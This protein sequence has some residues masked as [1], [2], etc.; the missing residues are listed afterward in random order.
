[1][2]LQQ[3]LQN[4]GRQRA[5]LHEPPF[6]Q[7][8]RH[9]AEHARADRL[10]VV[11]DQHRRVAIEADVA[12]VAPALFLHR[13]DD[14]R[15]DHLPLLDGPFRGRFLH[16][17]GD[18]VAEARVTPGRTA[19]RVDDRDLARAGIVGDVEDRSHLNHDCAPNLTFV[20]RRSRFFVPRRSTTTNVERRTSNVT[21]YRRRGADD[22]GQGPAL[23]AAHRP[24]LGDRDDVADLGGV[25]FVMDHELRGPPL[26][27]A[28]ETVAY[29]PLDGDDDALLHL[30]ADDDADFF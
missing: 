25:L 23:P 28:V 18:D 10:V 12:A 21:L 14:H 13:P 30:V 6:T 24:R 8:A 11:V 1:M 3:A 17:R 4:L 15:F 20:V 9:R 19:Q 5:D 7:L 29:L 27:L 22:A 26:G 16:R 2:L